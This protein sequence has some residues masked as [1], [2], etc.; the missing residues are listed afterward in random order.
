[1]EDRNNLALS[2]LKIE[3][4]NVI[5]DV[6]GRL[7]KGWTFSIQPYLDGVQINWKKP[8][9]SFMWRSTGWDRDIV[10]LYSIDSSGDHIT[11]HDI[12]DL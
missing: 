12:K 6:S 11:L 5:S 7:G 1:M 8:N 2:N 9:N 3:D 4:L 10:E